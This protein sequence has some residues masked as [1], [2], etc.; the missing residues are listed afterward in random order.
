MTME[1]PQDKMIGQT[2]G[3]YQIESKLGS[4]GMATVYLAHQT[5]IG[6]YVAIKVLPAHFL[7]DPSFLKR[8]Q[9]EVQIIAK[10]QHPRILPVYDYGMH[11][12]SPYIVMSY[13]PG[14]TLTERIQEGPMALGEVVSLMEAIAQGLD[15]AHA[16]GIVHRDFK[17][18]NVLLDKG[19]N[20]YLADFGIAKMAEG[21]LAMTGSGII[22][23]PAYIAPE[24]AS[25]GVAGP[26]ADMYA[27]GVS[28]YQMLTGRLPFEFET[29]MRTMMAHISDPVPDIR[30]LRP[31]L[32]AGIS[33]VLVKA[34]A[35]EPT[36][37]YKTAKAFALAL[38]AASGIV[39]DHDEQYIETVADPDGILA[40][41]SAGFSAPPTDILKRKP[42]DQTMQER[43]APPYETEPKR[44]R[45]R[46][47]FPIVGALIA[48]LVLGGLI[49]GG[50]LLYPQ[51]MAAVAGGDDPA[52]TV[53]G[54][55]DAGATQTSQAANNA[56]QQ[57]ATSTG[58]AGAT[59][60]ANAGATTVAQVGS[61][62]AT[63]TAVIVQQTQ[64]AL[65]QQATADGIANQ[66]ATTEAQ[67]ISVTA[68]QQ[69]RA[70]VLYSNYEEVLA[71]VQQGAFE[72][73][74]L[75]LVGTIDSLPIDYQGNFELEHNP[76]VMPIIEYAPGEDYV[77]FMAQAVF[78]SPF[79]TRDGL[80]DIGIIFR[81][82][83]N[84]SNDFQYRLRYDAVNSWGLE[85]RRGADIRPLASTNGG[86]F[87][88]SENGSNILTLIV[89]DT[90]AYVVL[91][92]HFIQK[93]DIFELNPIGSIGVGIGFA[94]Q[95]QLNGKTTPVELTIWKLP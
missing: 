12:G 22:G 4:G 90:R 72:E 45:P 9:M 73:N 62:S 28:T 23:T 41:P 34:L 44:D 80:W 31:E 14:G 56:T 61:D 42:A 94:P 48:L 40:Q 27:L 83:D 20:P 84:G 50:V 68:T 88:T 24:M 85:S 10:L 77:D 47:A 65:D 92:G 91:N 46:A 13:L 38:R 79:T 71:S 53:A 89:V 52:T 33:R 60:S 1:P 21:T 6:R 63:G 30:I 2:V 35:K 55:G 64:A 37:R 82:A 66:T 7:H 39:A 76:S 54:A 95:K 74:V 57:A 19:G 25:E 11:E 26:P 5:S 3:Q 36:D 70:T 16:E 81:S 18:S 29:P 8:F 17:P 87:D 93:V 51:I 69:A 32:P 49:V 78:T 59:A 86:W 75:A 67:S 15:H 58:V 43:I